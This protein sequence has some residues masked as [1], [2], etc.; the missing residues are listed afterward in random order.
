MCISLLIV[1]DSSACLQLLSCDQNIGVGEKWDI[2]GDGE[3]IAGV[4]GPCPQLVQR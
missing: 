4:W 3:R 2:R 1:L